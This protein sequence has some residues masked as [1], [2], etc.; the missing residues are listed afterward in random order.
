[1]C[2]GR[3]AVSAPLLAPL[4][5]LKFVEIKKDGPNCQ[6]ICVYILIISMKSIMKGNGFYQA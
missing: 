4:V 2:S 1:M 3:V 6:K 5:L